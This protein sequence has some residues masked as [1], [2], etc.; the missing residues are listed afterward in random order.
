MYKLSSII[1]IE[2][3]IFNMNVYN[4]KKIKF[5]EFEGMKINQIIVV[6]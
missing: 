4:I 3:H 6:L 1:I 2:I 5:I